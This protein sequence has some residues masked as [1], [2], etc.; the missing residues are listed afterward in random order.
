MTNHI[1]SKKY[2]VLGKCPLCGGNVIEGKNA[3]GCSNWRDPMKCKFVI[4]KKTEYGPM[5]KITVSATSVKKWLK[6]GAVSSKRLV[7]KDGNQF[8]AD[9]RIEFNPQTQ[10]VEY[11]LEFPQKNN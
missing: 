4:W 5:R 9:I 8:S 3:F 6:G 10:R 1:T 11:K 7:T 2:T